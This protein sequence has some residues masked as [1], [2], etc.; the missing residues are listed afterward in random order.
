MTFCAC[1]C[2]LVSGPTESDGIHFSIALALSKLHTNLAERNVAIHVTSLNYF[3]L[4]GFHKH[5]AA[6]GQFT[7][8]PLV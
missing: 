1:M 3:L 2:F 6:F 8:Q 7:E 4:C 5:G